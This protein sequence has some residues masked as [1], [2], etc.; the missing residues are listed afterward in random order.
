M[1]N[2]MPVVPVTEIIK[3]LELLTQFDNL[4]HLHKVIGDMINTL[5][6]KSKGVNSNV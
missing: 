5:E 4:D 1:K 2:K 6:Y 3:M